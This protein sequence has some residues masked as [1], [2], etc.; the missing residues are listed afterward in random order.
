M[1]VPDD[2]I[3]RFSE[4]MFDKMPKITQISF[5]AV[6]T[7]AQNLYYHSR[8]L[9]LYEDMILYAPASVEEYQANLGK[10]TRY[11][12]RRN[13]NRLAR[14]FPTF[15]FRALGEQEITEEKL[16]RLLKFSRERLSEKSIIGDDEAK[17]QLVL[18]MVERYGFVTEAQ[19]NGKICGGLVFYKINGNYFFRMIAHDPKYDRYSLGFV[20]CYL[21]FSEVIRQGGRMLNLGWDKYEYKTRL[22]GVS[23]K[24]FDVTIYRS[25]F[26]LML[27]IPPVLNLK[28]RKFKDSVLAFASNKQGLVANFTHSII[29]YRRRAMYQAQLSKVKYRK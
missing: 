11:N 14:D 4:Y 2:E 7:N 5:R 19:I 26:Y 28:V 16:R 10:N 17:F 12:M 1:H 20:L 22:G 3:R 6:E 24:L 13:M 25:Y 9:E 18:Q 23:R 21:S 15:S 27:D 8:S 29:L